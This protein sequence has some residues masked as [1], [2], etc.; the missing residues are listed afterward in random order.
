[1][2]LV[3]SVVLLVALSIAPAAAAKDAPSKDEIRFR[4]VTRDNAGVVLCGLFKQGGW[5]KQPVR[6]ARATVSG[7]VAVCVFRDVKPGVYAISAFHDAN[8]NGKLDK[9]FIGIPTEGFCASRDARARFGPPSFKDARFRYK[10][11]VSS[12]QVR[13]RYF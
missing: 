3:R 7:R 13:M 12:M 9:N 8:D 4:S 11:G 6:S 2:A 10:G 1:V 5:L